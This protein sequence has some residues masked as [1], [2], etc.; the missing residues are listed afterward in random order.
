MKSYLSLTFYL[1]L[2]AFL[3]FQPPQAGSTPEGSAISYD[4]IKHK[5]MSGISLQPAE[6][7]FWRK[8]QS[9]GKPAKPAQ[10]GPRRDDRG[11]PDDFGYR[12][13]DS[14]ENGGPEYEWI[15]ISDFDDVVNINGVGDDTNH[16]PYEL[17]F[18]FPYYD[19]EFDRIRYCSN[20]W[21]SF[22]NSTSIYN[23]QNFDL[24]SRNLPENLLAVCLTDWNPNNGG[25]TYMFWTDEDM[26]VLTW[27]NIPHIDQGN[28]RWTFQII[29]TPNGMIKYQYAQI[30]QL[31][32]NTLIGFQ[33]DD[34]DDGL[35]IY[36]GNGGN[37]DEEYAIR[38]SAAMGWLT[39]TVTDLETDEP[40]EGAAITLSDGNQ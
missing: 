4:L 30:N 18:D 12:W 38:I 39:G 14:D 15:D 13:V 2:V 7:E 17:G 32:R 26:A 40:I 35:T 16:G 11:G 9:E 5:V 37:L 27:E 23:F 33:N 10:R 36:Q 3:V 31:Q 19:N 24:P 25:G 29:L 8:V 20:G 1:V 34:Q 22:T 21:A 28:A 6:Q